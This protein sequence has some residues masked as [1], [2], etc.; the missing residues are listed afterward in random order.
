[1]RLKHFLKLV[2]SGLILCLLFSC[3]KKKE[4]AS[5]L[6]VPAHLLT[7]HQMAG[8]LTQ[9]HLL[10]AAVNLKTAQNQ[11]T[12]RRD[13]VAYSDI[14]QKYQ[15]TYAEFKEN[16]AYYS[17]KPDELEV[18]YDEVISELTRMQAVEERKKP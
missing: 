15:S 11:S 17:S 4:E 6:P 1:M 12:N 10:E 8:L 9:V 3:G 5:P 13:S 16:F 14:F 7:P 18:I 2:T